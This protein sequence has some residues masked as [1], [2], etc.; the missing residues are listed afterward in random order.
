MAPTPDPAAALQSFAAIWGRAV[1]PVSQ[2]RLEP[3][4]LQELLTELTNRLR[5]ALHAQPFDP[6]PGRAVGTALVA[7]GYA[8]PEALNQSL[9]V[10]HAYL[11]LY[12]PPPPVRLSPGPNAEELAARAARLQHAVAAGFAQGVAERAA[13]D[14]AAA[15]AAADT[16]RQQAE[17]ARHAAEARFRALFAE[18]AV[19]ICVI[20]LDGL[21]T[22]VNPAL[23]GMFGATVDQLNGSQVT[24]HEHP[25]DG[26]E[27]WTL[28]ADLVRGKRE[29]YRVEKPYFRV[30]GSVFWADQTV[31]LIRGADGSPLCQLAIL[32]DITER[33]MLHKLLRHQAT[34]DPLTGL[35]NRSLFLERLENA[36]DRDG[37]AERVALCYLDLDAFKTVN[38]SL[39]HDIGD[40][41][42]VAVADRF[43][44]CLSGPH[45]LVAR[46]GGDE[47]TALI[48]DPA[49]EEEAVALAQRFLDALDEPVVID[50]QDLKI[51]V[52]VG[53][54]EGPVAALDPAKAVQGAD[55][56]LY[57][58]KAAGGNRW[59]VN[60]PEA[61]EV[62]IRRH[63]LATNLPGAL[64]RGE[65]FVE[66]QPLVSLPDGRIRAA[67]A[68]VRWRHPEHGVLGP[69]RFVPIAESTGLIV[70]LG[71]WVLEQACKQVKSWQLTLDDPGLRVNVNLSPRQTRS[72]TLLK[73]VVHALDESGLEAS[74]LCL[75]VTESAL[76]GADGQSLAALRDL[77]ALGITLAL[78]DFGTGYANFSHLRA[79]PVHCLK[80]DR[81]FVDGLAVTIEPDADGGVDRLDPADRIKGAGVDAALVAGMVSL[82]RS[83]DLAVTAEGIETEEQARRLQE[84]GCDTAQGWFY[85]RPGS[86]EQFVQLSRER[87]LAS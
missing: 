2:A 64:E 55:L 70:P 60:D 53:V 54:L 46:M 18:A 63:T 24:D 17:E 50:G 76:I 27:V 84:L 37:G 45:Q 36:L 61:N 3:A 79:M 40:R 32:Q 68:L 38:D 73:D 14:R 62:E 65:F 87:A 29:H 42:L 13:A 85:A 19:G 23:A 74:S 22:E 77:A 12:F 30:D 8:E 6:A 72:P 34:H 9:G 59:A 83:L 81:S 44:R 41:V 31:T 57:R 4:E 67:E 86:P 69:D 56:T 52:S 47:F 10:L 15:D 33:R 16:A 39:G 25:L 43:R 7:A 75:E 21:I 66:Y 35:P 49:D 48:V 58:A 26:P 80:I 28:Y 78:D 82:A 20:S 1:H 71:R 51:T 11:T 5:T